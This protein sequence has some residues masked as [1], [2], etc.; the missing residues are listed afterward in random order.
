MHTRRTLTAAILAAPLAFVAMRTASAATYSQ[1]DFEA[2]QKAGKPIL[3][4]ISAPWCPVCK[5]Q[6]PILSKLR[7]D[8]ALKDLVVLDVDFDTSKDLLKT[9]NVQKQ[10]TL[11]VYHGATE[12]GRSTGETNEA[13]IKA[14]LMKA[15]A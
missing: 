6:H 3:L 8:P 1:A 11:I 15:T 12:K 4:H 10:S 13:A 7:T 2:A 5:Q 14:L 9:L